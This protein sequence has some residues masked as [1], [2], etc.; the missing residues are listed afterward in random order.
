MAGVVELMDSPSVWCV[1]VLFDD[2]NAGV[3]EKEEPLVCGTEIQQMRQHRLQ[4]STVADDQDGFAPLLMF[5][6][7]FPQTPTDSFPRVEH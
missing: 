5:G 1:R 3:V 4:R 2:G 7:N 6:E